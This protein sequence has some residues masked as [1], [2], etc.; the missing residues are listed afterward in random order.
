MWFLRKKFKTKTMSEII[1]GISKRR[2]NDGCFKFIIVS[3]ESTFEFSYWYN[4]EKQTTIL[5]EKTIVSN[6]IQE[7]KFKITGHEDA[8]SSLEYSQEKKESGSKIY[9]DDEKE[10]AGVIGN[11][12]L[13]KLTA[14]LNTDTHY[15]DSELFSNRYKKE[16]YSNMFLS[17]SLFEKGDNP[18][19]IFLHKY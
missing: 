4:G 19:E 17:V 18:V 3:K 16:P 6:G 7:R 13:N 14:H 15:V 8:N 2:L 9:C 12:I 1:E 11:S 5:I 10:K